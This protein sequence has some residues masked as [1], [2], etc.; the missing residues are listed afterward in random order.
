MTRANNK[1]K[2]QLK[3]NNVLAFNDVDGYNATTIYER[4]TRTITI[5]TRGLQE[6]VFTVYSK[7]ASSTAYFNLINKISAYKN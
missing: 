3:I 7:N 4:V 2:L 6:F 5:T 1:G